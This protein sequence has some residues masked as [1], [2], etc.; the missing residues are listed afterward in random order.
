MRAIFGE[1]GAEGFWRKAL[2]GGPGVLLWSVAF[3]LI[4][5]KL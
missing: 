2:V 3:G 4:L 5:G 1:E